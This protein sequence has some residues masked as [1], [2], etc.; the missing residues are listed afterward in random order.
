MSENDSNTHTVAASAHRRS[1]V[2]S[3]L[4]LG[5]ALV[6]STW[7]V[8]RI[9]SGG[10]HLPR[11]S[12]LVCDQPTHDFGLLT[13]EQTSTATHRFTL[14]NT[15]AHPIRIV[16]KASSCGCTTAD[17]PNN[18]VVAPRG[19][20]NMSLKA[21]WRDRD[22]YQT[23]RVM[24]VTDEATSAPLAL[25]ITGRV[26]S[27]IRI[28]PRHLDFG[29]LDPGPS[30]E[31]LF[32]VSHGPHQPAFRIIEVRTDGPSVE[33]RRST[34]DQTVGSEPAKF[35]VRVNVRRTKGSDRIPIWLYTSLDPRPISVL[36]T[37]RSRGAISAAPES[38]FF[39]FTKK[40]AIDTARVHVRIGGAVVTKKLDA[41]IVANTDVGL[42]LHIQ[43]I[44][45]TTEGGAASADVIVRCAAPVQGVKTAVLRIK[46]GEDH[47]D[48]PIA[49]I[50]GR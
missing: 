24:L 4:M 14:R 27:P 12:G 36:V 29:E 8:S 47:V 5:V 28:W 21:D 48:V 33:V 32:E 25:T 23:A 9:I 50:G 10:R 19:T 42:P 49:L 45:T 22:G 44:I 1:I 18:A 6:F 46:S 13:P 30:E 26:E 31:K 16:R 35:A 7:V 11:L 17:L 3:V 38:I 20:L 43:R 37:V 40:P 34:V 15:S 39:D 2:L 41:T